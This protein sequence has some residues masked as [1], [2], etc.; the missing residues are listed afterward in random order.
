MKTFAKLHQY[1][2]TPDFPLG[3]RLA[4]TTLP[5]PAARAENRPE[6]RQADLTPEES[7]VFDAAG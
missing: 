7:D 5:G 2:V 6:I 3:L 4:L 1:R